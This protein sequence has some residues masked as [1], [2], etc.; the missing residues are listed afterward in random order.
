MGD[1]TM[2]NFCTAGTVMRAYTPEKQSATESGGR[3]SLTRDVG[4]AY[5]GLDADRKS[6][7]VL[8]TVAGTSMDRP[9][10]TTTTF[11]SGDA[12]QIDVLPCPASSIRML[13]GRAFASHAV[14]FMVPE[15]LGGVIT[16]KRSGAFLAAQEKRKIEISA[17]KIFADEGAA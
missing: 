8:D 14:I 3:S 2:R 9:A 4:R 15:K 11:K 7:P 5:F 6:S 13:S 12:E 10:R 1:L 16:V 17:T